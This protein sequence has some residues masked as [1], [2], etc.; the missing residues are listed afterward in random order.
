VPNNKPSYYVEPIEILTE[1]ERRRRRT[2]QENRHRAGNTQAG[3][4]RVGGGTPPPRE[5]QPG[6][7]LAQ[8]IPVR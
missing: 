3:S 8:A 6:V 2:A 1:P 5:Y 4:I 7:R